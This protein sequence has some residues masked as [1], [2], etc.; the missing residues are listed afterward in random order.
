MGCGRIG[1]SNEERPVGAVSIEGNAGQLRS[2]VFSLGP[3]TTRRG[4]HVRSVGFCRGYFRMRFWR[5]WEGALA[6]AREL[7]CGKI[8]RARSARDASALAVASPNRVHR[9]STLGSCSAM[10]NGL[11][12]CAAPSRLPTTCLV[13]RNVP[14]CNR[15]RREAAE[16]D[17]AARGCQVLALDPHLARPQLL[18]IANRSARAAHVQRSGVSHFGS[19]VV[20]LS[21]RHGASGYI[22][23][24][25]CPQLSLSL[26]TL[27]TLV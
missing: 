19:A 17:G 4:R 27:A 22:A 7:A 3:T 12:G 15:T 6:G 21:L 23:R 11:S 1:C 14:S 5:P 13:A 16:T 2:A 8:T 25:V 10:S 26:S 18:N 20:F 24:S 9:G